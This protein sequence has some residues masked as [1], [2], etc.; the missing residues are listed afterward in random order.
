MGDSV[1]RQNRS[2]EKGDKVDKI[3]LRILSCARACARPI[4]LAVVVTDPFLRFRSG[5]AIVRK[6]ET[7]SVPGTAC[8]AL[9]NLSGTRKVLKYN[10]SHCS[11]R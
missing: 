2:A 11:C 10:L 4:R 9:C 1:D 6:C 3:D 7:S 5:T 8:A